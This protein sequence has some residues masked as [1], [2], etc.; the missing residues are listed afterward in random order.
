MNT[1]ILTSRVTDI[2]NAGIMAM[3]RYA[4]KYQ[5][6]ISLGQ[7]TPLFPTP[8]FIYDYVYE[9][10]KKE[11]AVG[12]YAETPMNNE[13]KSLIVKQMEKLYGF[14]PDTNRLMITMGGVGALNAAI[15]TV[16]G[17]GDEVIYFDPSYP[18]HL[19]QIHIAQAKPVF[20]SLDEQN[21]WSLDMEKLKS[22]ITPATKAIILTNPN[23]PTGT[24]LSENQIREMSFLILKNKNH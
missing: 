18:I 12:M 2:P 5:D 11:K 8:Q 24:V 19:S 23:N 17:P 1:N 6:V 14:T 15:M 7:G 20:V 16:L 3:M 22:S 10:A 4:S 13:L 9:R 21:G